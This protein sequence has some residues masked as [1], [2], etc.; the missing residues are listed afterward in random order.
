MA[1]RAA[2]EVPHAA[3]VTIDR[4]NDQ[5]IRLV[6]RLAGHQQGRPD[7]LLQDDLRA[8]RAAVPRVR[9]FVGW[10]DE[11]GALDQPA[12]YTASADALRLTT[13]L[14][15][16]VATGTVANAICAACR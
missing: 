1:A 11:H 3:I 10:G 6:L 14:K 13:W 12:L 15:E 9:S 16:L 4:S 5:M 8:L 2:C 7:R